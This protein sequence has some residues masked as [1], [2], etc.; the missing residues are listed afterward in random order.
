MPSQTSSNSLA[1]KDK[2]I[3][4]TRPAHQAG[5]IQKKLEQAGAN[6]I[7]FPLLEITAPRNPKLAKQQLS[8]ITTYDLIIFVSPNSALQSLRWIDKYN[9]INSDTRIASIGKK[10]AATLDQQGLSPDLFP[11]K[12]FNS[13]AFLALPEIQQARFKKVAI[14]RGEGGRNLL[15]DTLIKRGV[16]VDNID[17]YQRTCPQTN[18]LILKQHWQRKELDIIMLTSGSSITN[19][20]KLVKNEDWINQVKLLLGSQRMQQH[21]PKCFHDNVIIADDPSDET[22]YNKL[23]SSNI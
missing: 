13:E 22:L 21:V 6:V 7:L 12:H 17:T 20:F 23:L 16:S 5:A 9:L 14:I 2:W 18:T 8:Q 15:H 3:V 11:K 1:L 4:V 10:T 19:L